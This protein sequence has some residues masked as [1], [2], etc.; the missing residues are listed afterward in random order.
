M[1]NFDGRG[2]VT[3][4]GRMGGRRMGIK[5]GLSPISA[6]GSLSEALKNRVKKK[7]LMTK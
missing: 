6:K 2:P 4:E 5:T 1:P 7:R 3:G